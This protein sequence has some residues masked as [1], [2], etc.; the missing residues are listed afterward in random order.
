M[1]VTHIEDAT[2]TRGGE[3]WVLT[4]E[5]GHVFFKR[6]PRFDLASHL[7]HLIERA[8][9]TERAIREHK[10]RQLRGAPHRMKCTICE[11]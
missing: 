9:K 7:P 1:L 6:K 11:S 3:M 5:C 4:L 8:K 2:G 10:M